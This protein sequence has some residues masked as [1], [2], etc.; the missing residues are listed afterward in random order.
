MTPNRAAKFSLLLTL[1]F[2]FC[3]ADNIAAAPWF[4]PSKNKDGFE[5]I[6]DLVINTSSEAKKGFRKASNESK[7]L[8][9]NAIK[10]A[11]KAYHETMKQ[12]KI[13]LDHAATSYDQSARRTED[14]HSKSV[15]KARETYEQIQAEGDTEK[16]IKAYKQAV[17]EANDQQR[18]LLVEAKNAYLEARK[19]FLQQ[20]F[21]AEKQ[22]QKA[23]A[24]A[25]KAW[26]AT[27][28]TADD[29]FKKMI[30]S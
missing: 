26:N 30:K 25:L 4:N 23:K 18:S 19:G 29:N 5:K 21:E 3:C 28:K 10:V 24:D 27:S 20:S 16:A 13:D 7:D 17:A 6:E 9:F 1:C 11:E 8:Y 12:A 15:V 2:S 22:L 14:A